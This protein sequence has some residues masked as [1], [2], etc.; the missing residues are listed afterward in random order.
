MA[1]PVL[2]TSIMTHTLEKILG[3]F[4]VG[5]GTLGAGGALGHRL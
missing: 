3:I 1:D 5:A 4:E 2:D